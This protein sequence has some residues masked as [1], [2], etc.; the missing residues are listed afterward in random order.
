MEARAVF[1]LT[2]QFLM[3]A[4][5]ITK[6]ANNTDLST[7]G[8]TFQGAVTLTNSSTSQ[9]RL[10]GTNPDIFN[11]A[12]SLVSGNTG[13]IEVAYTLQPEHNSI[14]TFQSP[15]ILQELLHLEQMVELQR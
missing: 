6:T 11:G 8:N 13:P 5:S 1:S 3:V 10:A 2:D 14:K 7:G 4:V 12:L 15:I 9:F